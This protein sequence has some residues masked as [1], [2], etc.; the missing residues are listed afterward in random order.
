M[1]KKSIFIISAV[2]GF[3][4][5]AEM[6]SHTEVDHMSDMISDTGSM[7]EEESGFTG[8][9]ELKYGDV[10]Q[11]REA[12][13]R[14]RLG[15]QGNVNESVKWAVGVSSSSGD[16]SGKSIVNSVFGG[17][18]VTPIALE[19]A[20]VSYSPVENFSVLAGKK[21]FKPSFHK[22]GV[23]YDEDLYPAGA[24]VKYRH[25]EDEDPASFYGKVGVYELDS[26][27]KGPF[28]EGGILFGKVG[29]KFEF[30]EGV[31][32]GVYVSADYGGLFNKTVESTTTVDTAGETADETETEESAT[33]E[34]TNDVTLA[35]VGVHVSA[36]M[37]I[38]VGVFGAYMTNVDQLG[39]G[40]NFT[41]GVY[42]GEAG[43]ASPGSAN[44]FGL[45]V[46][47]HEIDGNHFNTDLLNRDYF[48]GAGK[49]IAVRAQY[50]PWDNTNFVAKFAH[51]LTD[52]VDSDK[53]NSLHGELTFHF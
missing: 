22:V 25:G 28:S 26:A 52:G 12:S 49:G 5:V 40:L 33:T 39:E 45:A 20:Y 42:A 17:P 24:W 10:L 31:K 35:K 43:K 44:D 50:N 38:P 46:S 9:V 11:E 32:A 19:Q 1:F 13:Y 34:S 6:H 36:D 8:S 14:A 21:S 4:S 7:E 53:A 48:T 23:L 3:S 30:A 18:G 41:G 51:N 27:Y 47:Y 37:G 2:F 16:M 15:W 29:A